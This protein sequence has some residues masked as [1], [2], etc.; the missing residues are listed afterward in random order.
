MIS[1]TKTTFPIDIAIEL[2]KSD[3]L[4]AISEFKKKAESFCRPSD[5]RNEDFQK[6]LKKYMLGIFEHDTYKQDLESNPYSSLAMSRNYKISVN[7]PEMFK[8]TID[9]F[10]KIEWRNQR[11]NES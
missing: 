4:L 6:E 3:R 9:L 5:T 1:R 10:E 2:L 8:F 11:Q 7:K